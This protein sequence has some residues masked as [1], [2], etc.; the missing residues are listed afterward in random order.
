MHCDCSKK[1]ESKRLKLRGA[2]GPGRR[3][4]RTG[5]VLLAVLIITFVLTLSAYLFSDAMRAESLATR[6]YTRAAQ[7]RALAD[8]GI[9]YAAAILSNPDLFTNTLNSNPFNNAQV[10]QGITVQEDT[11]SSAHGHF[12]IVAALGPDYAASESQPYW[13]GVTDESGKIN[14]NAVMKLDSS[15]QTLYN[16]L[17][18]LPN[19]TDDVA[20]SI[21]DWLDPD[22]NPRENGAESDYYSSLSPPYQAK[23]GPL[24]SLEEL[25]LVKGVTPELLFGNDR[26]R[27]GILDPDE[28]DGSGIVDQGW[29]TYLTVY[30]REL[31]VDSS[32]N[33]RIYV[34]MQDLNTLYTNL[35]TAVGQDLANYILAARLYGVQSGTPPSNNSGSQGNGSTGTAGNP[36]GANNNS[37]GSSRGTSSGSGT[38]ART[39]SAN[40]SPAT[41]ARLS[42]SNLG[43]FQQG[44]PQRISSLYSLINSYVQIPA[45]TPG[46]QPTNY[47]S[48]LNDASVQ[49]QYLPLLLDEVST[50]QGIDLTPRINVNTAPQAVLIALEAFTNL[51]DSDVQ[52][53][54]DHRPSPLDTDPPD[55]IYQTPAWLVTEASMSPQKVQT[56]DRYITARSQVY[57]VQSLGYFDEGGPTARVEAVIDTN[58]GRP[59]VIYYRDLTELGKG[60]SP[61]SNQ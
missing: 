29:S 41:P 22:D 44:R 26:N 60:F 15:G 46:G 33:P 21:I 37:S 36:A 39:G 54:L 61:P 14:L 53:I 4:R 13:L 59:R 2:T 58:A 27:N 17:M 23:N 9:D 56:L 16:M 43:N 55:P 34:N 11:D 28:D 45:S 50:S 24:D 32:G 18:Q 52:A 42:R 7:A 57:R 1:R 49:K 3:D 12:S 19:M 6:S 38:N 30:G 10:F 20:N 31:N 25:L 35:T 48:P 51:S 47:P 5:V 8:S 40:N